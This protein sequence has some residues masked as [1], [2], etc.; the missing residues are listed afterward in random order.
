MSRFDRIEQGEIRKIAKSVAPAAGVGG[1][2]AATHGNGGA[3]EISIDASQVTTGLLNNARIPNHAGSHEEGGGDDINIDAGQIYAG[4]FVDARIPS[5]D[6]SKTTTGVFSTSRLGSGTAA[7]GNFLDGTSAWKI[8]Y[9]PPK[10]IPFSGSIDAPGLWGD[11]FS[12]IALVANT[13]KMVPFVPSF[14]FTPSVIGTNI[15]SIVVGNLQ[16]AIYASNPA[17]GLPVGT[18][19]NTPSNL[20]T[21]TTGNRETAYTTAVVA[22]TQYWLAIQTSAACTNR[23]VTLGSLVAIVS[24]PATASQATIFNKVITFGTWINF[25]SVPAVVGDFVNGNFPLVYL[26][27]A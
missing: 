20:S 4:V 21:N 27:R 6:A 25:T 26:R 13:Q 3:D 24:D 10:V 18:P 15:T 23:S 9:A 1:L 2:H 12:T 17:T 11:A 16:L 22:G 7:A 14:S 19:L 5:L 8:P